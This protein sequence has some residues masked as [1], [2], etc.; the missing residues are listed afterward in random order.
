MPVPGTNQKSVEDIYIID[1]KEEA[2]NEAK[3]KIAEIVLNAYKR[4]KKKENSF[5]SYFFDDEGNEFYLKE[6]IYN[7]PVVVCNWSDGTKTV[8]KCDEMDDYCIE[9]GLVICVLK[10]LMGCKYFARLIENWTPDVYTGELTK[11]TLKDVLKRQ[12]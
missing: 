12:S 5:G 7:N 6:V 3:S 1:K 2:V 10:K 8:A 4:A 9:T 11:I